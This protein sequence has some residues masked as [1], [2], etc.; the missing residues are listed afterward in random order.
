MVSHGE[1][2]GLVYAE[3]MTQGLP[4][5]YTLGTGFDNMYPQ[6]QIGYGVDSHSVDSIA[7]GLSDIINN[8]SDL[9]SNV[10]QAD[11]GRY[12]WSSIAKVYI[13]IYNTIK[14]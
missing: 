13:K 2:F 12:S 3:C 8:Y 10:S 1:T 4:L 6:G 11:Y 7:E 14:K 9:R 5:L